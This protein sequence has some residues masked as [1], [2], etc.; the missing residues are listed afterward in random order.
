MHNASTTVSAVD[1]LMTVRELLDLPSFGLR[2]VAAPE[3]VDRGLRWAHPTELP[4][5]RRYLT[6][7]ELVM[8]VGSGLTSP[9]AQRQFVH[10]LIEVGVSA[11]AYGVGDVTEDIPTT[12]VEECRSLG[13]PLVRVSEGIRFQ[14]ITSLL[15]DRRTEAQTARGRRV[16]R[17]TARLLDAITVDR[18]ISE[19]LALMATALGGRFEFDHGALHWAPHHPTDTS[20]AD[21]VLAHLASVLTVRQ[22]GTDVEVAAR[23]REAGRLAELVLQGRADPAVLETD[24]LAAGLQPDRDVVPAAWPAMVIELV[25]ERVPECMVAVI[26]EVALTLSADREAVLEVARELALPAGIGEAAPVGQLARTVPPALSALRLGRDRGA[27]VLSS[28]LTTFDA[29]LERQPPAQLAAYAEQLVGPLADHDLRHGSALVSTLRAYLASDGA[30]G[31]TAAALFTHPNTVR[32][33]I[34]QIRDLIGRDP[35]RFADLT[36]LAVALWAWDH[37]PRTP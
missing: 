26:R 33:R 8:T 20:P 35:Q 1:A 12:L 21:D 23:R 14:D 9:E 17:L 27:P 16:Q 5:P 31:R 6:G 13:L 30:P 34:R 19:L 2:L 32:Y 36:S 28:E 24:L 25:T 4:D 11:L 3:H 22:H 18:P 10:H 37:R 7:G 29:L 15:A